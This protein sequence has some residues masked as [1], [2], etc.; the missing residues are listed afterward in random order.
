MSRLIKT[1]SAGKQ[2]A[3]MMKA[4]ALALRALAARAQFDTEARDLAA[5][6]VL[7]LREIHATIDVT[8]VAWEKRDY[9]LKADQFRREWAWA[10]RA[11][12]KLTPILHRE[13][14]HHLPPLMVELSK[15]VAKIELP[16]RNTLGAPWV[17]A[18][19]KLM[20]EN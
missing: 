5:F 18:Y 8:C 20:Q 3:Q 17:G 11:A 4:L 6:L 7:A 9:W 10:G 1:D 14:W 19:G 13:E 2:R 12:E 16:K 15:Y